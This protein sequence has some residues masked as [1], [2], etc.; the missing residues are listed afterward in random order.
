M[1]NY[2]V[3]KNRSAAQFIFKNQPH[4]RPIKGQEPT[5]FRDAL[6]DELPRVLHREDND[7]V[8]RGDIK[9]RESCLVV[10]QVLPWD[11]EDE[12][13]SDRAVTSSPREG[14]PDLVELNPTREETRRSENHCIAVVTCGLGRKGRQNA[15]KLLISTMQCSRLLSLMR[16]GKGTRSQ[17][18]TRCTEEIEIE[19]DIERE[20]IEVR[21]E[22]LS[23][24]SGEK[25]SPA[26]KC[27]SRDLG[28]TPS[29]AKWYVER[30]CRNRTTVKST[31]GF[32]EDLDSGRVDPDI[33]Y[34]GAGV[35]NH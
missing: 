14:F 35:V 2:I 12:L 30:T 34:D 9:P 15:S 24:T 4:G 26:D 18:P 10:A 7:L 25:I 8:Y 17:E 33:P 11:S 20:R 3:E 22:R 23:P 21:R 1:P 19:I 28:S 29:S 13:D 27:D 31:E 32:Q 16:G 5:N 6:L